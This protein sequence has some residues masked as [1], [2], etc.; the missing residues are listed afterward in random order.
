MRVVI[1]LLEFIVNGL[2][3]EARDSLTELQ[4]GVPLSTVKSITQTGY[5]STDKLHTVLYNKT[6][7]ID[8]I[9]GS[10]NIDV[11]I[12][13]DD[14]TM[15]GAS[16]SLRTRLQVYT[17][18]VE[19]TSGY[20]NGRIYKVKSI[21]TTNLTFKL[22]GM[23]SSLLV[24]G[25]TLKIQRFTTVPWSRIA[26]YQR[27]E[28]Q[29]IL[30]SAI[31]SDDLSITVESATNIRIGDRGFIDREWIRITNK[32][33]N[34]LTIVRAINN[35]YT[36]ETTT[37]KSHG[38]G[39]VF[40]IKVDRCY[41]DFHDNDENSNGWSYVCL[42]NQKDYYTRLTDSTKPC[43]NTTCPNYTSDYSFIRKVTIFIESD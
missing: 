28:T 41:Y 8:S 30:A 25:D 34:V 5:T 11:N 35:P 26:E 15:T 10:Y 24:A 17:D 33:G 38:I 12:T 4:C 18:Y 2:P 21:N 29:G 7:T 16:D 6:C 19:I 31:D 23:E 39:S 37:A 1:D 40:Q 14:F 20:L 42:Q 13:I 43:T 32:V 9:D 36:G 3:A 27:Y 22:L